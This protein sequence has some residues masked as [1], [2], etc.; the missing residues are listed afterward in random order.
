MADESKV[1]ARTLQT[2]RVHTTDKPDILVLQFQTAG[3]VENFAVTRDAMR[4]IADHL[5]KNAAGA[6]GTDSSGPEGAA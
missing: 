6:S 1:Q 4:Q 2:V 5:A 3:G